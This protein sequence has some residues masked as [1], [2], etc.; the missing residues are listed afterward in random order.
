MTS[1]GQD[2]RSHIRD[3]SPSYG[4]RR[5][6]KVSANRSGTSSSVVAR[7]NE[8]WVCV[9]GEANANPEFLFNWKCVKCIPELADTGQQKAET[10]LA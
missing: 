4:V 5:W 3:T 1:G 10:S 6:V 7:I 2:T 9:I 8:G